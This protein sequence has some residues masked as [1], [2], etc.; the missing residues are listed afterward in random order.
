M[1]P[2]VEGI[3]LRLADELTGNAYNAEPHQPD[4]LPWLATVVCLLIYTIWLMRR[5]WFVEVQ[6]CL[7]V[8]I[9]RALENPKP[10]DP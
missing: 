6:R 2:E 7:A 1:W 10:S 8:A 9:M 4:R 5:T 3:Y